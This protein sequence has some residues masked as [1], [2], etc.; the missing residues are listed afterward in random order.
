[1]ENKKKELEARFVTAALE[2]MDELDFFMEFLED[3]YTLQDIMKYIPEKYEYAR[4]FMA[5]HGLL[6]DDDFDVYTECHLTNSGKEK[7]RKFI[8]EC[9]MKRDEILES[10]EDTADEVS[11]PTVEGI[12]SDISSHV[13]K[14]GDYLNHWPITDSLREYDEVLGLTAEEDFVITET[15]KDGNG[16]VYNP[17]AFTIEACPWCESEQVIHVKGV[18]RCSCGKPL[19]PCSVCESCDYATCPYGCDGSD[20]DVN[21]KIDHEALPENVQAFLYKLL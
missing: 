21:K 17:D 10:E 18:T 7:V 8:Q 3:G 9:S 1:M 16:K 19:A 13:D 15:V 5:N 14:D 4:N 20:N 6:S 2:Q 12:V 11:L